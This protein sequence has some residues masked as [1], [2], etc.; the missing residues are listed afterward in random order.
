V[1]ANVSIEVPK[2]EEVVVRPFEESKEH[3]LAALALLEDRPEAN[4]I[5]AVGK[6]KGALEKLQAQ[7][8]K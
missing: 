3:I 4:A 1:P 7:P 6:L 8:T 2:P 5:L